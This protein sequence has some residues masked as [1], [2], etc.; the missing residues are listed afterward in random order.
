MLGDH[1]RIGVVELDKCHI[2][3]PYAYCIPDEY[4]VGDCYLVSK[5]GQTGRNHYSQRSD[6]RP[7]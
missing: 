1:R 6:G 2:V 5:I 4:V 7:V 3:T